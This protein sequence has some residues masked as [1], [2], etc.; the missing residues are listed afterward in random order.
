MPILA[1]ANLVQLVSWPLVGALV[2]RAARGK[3]VAGGVGRHRPPRSLC[4]N[5]AR[6]DHRRCAVARAVRG[7][8]R[9]CRLALRPLSRWPVHATVDRGA[10]EYRDRA[11]GHRRR[12][13]L[14][15][16]GPAVVAVALHRHVGRD[17][18][19]R[20]GV[21]VPPSLLGS[22]SANGRG[23]RCSPCWRWCSRTRCGRSLA[24]GS[25]L[26]RRAGSSLAVRRTGSGPRVR[27]RPAGAALAQR[28]RGAS[29]VHPAGLFIDYPRDDDPCNH[30]AR[31]GARR[32]RTGT[33]LDSGRCGRRA[34]H[35]RG[36]AL[37]EGGG[38]VRLRPSA[39]P[40]SSAR[41]TGAQNLP[42]S[43]TPGTCPRRSSRPAP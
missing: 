21:P 18:A 7:Y 3:G 22:R 20:P 26:I 4:R 38:P 19:R 29:M 8:E 16:R 28:R 6:R 37:P 13:G 36:R 35:P 41:G 27:S 14:R 24:S 43:Q 31:R 34:D 12:I 32:K 1:A 11:P 39:E 30:G 23:G 5:H 42:S 10:G 9:H 25:G 17:P 40:A 33:N 15:P 2:W